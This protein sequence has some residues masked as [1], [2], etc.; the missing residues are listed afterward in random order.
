MFRKY[1]LTYFI[2]TYMLMTPHS[3]Y[4][5]VRNTEM[6]M[7]GYTGPNVSSS[8][9]SE[10]SE[11]SQIPPTPHSQ[12]FHGQCPSPFLFHWLTQPFTHSAANPETWQLSLISPSLN[13]VCCTQPTQSCQ[14]YSLISLLSIHSPQLIWLLLQHLYQ[15]CSV[16]GP[17]LLFQVL[18]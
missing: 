16:Q 12:Y 3:P 18:V 15:N 4:V 11:V 7:N 5:G 1:S 13:L 6:V 17:E 8:S 10:D 14:F 9:H 2:P